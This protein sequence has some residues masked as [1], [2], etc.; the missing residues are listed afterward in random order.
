MSCQPEIGMLVY[1]A[2]LQIKLPISDD[3]V[4]KHP[5]CRGRDFVELF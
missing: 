3:S 4:A 2:S 5:N 1:K